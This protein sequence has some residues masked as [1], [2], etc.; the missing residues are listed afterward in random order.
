M[1]SLCFIY[2]N[3]YLFYLFIVGIYYII[4]APIYEKLGFEG[5]SGDKHLEILLRKRIV[6]LNFYY[7]ETFKLDFIIIIRFQIGLRKLD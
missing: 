7:S 3:I 5:K 4:L 2:L 6:S 1:S